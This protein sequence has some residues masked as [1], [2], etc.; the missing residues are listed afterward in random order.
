MESEL[1]QNNY[2]QI[3]RT[4]KLLKDLEQKDLFLCVKELREEIW[5]RNTCTKTAPKKNFYFVV[6]GR[7]KVFKIDEHSGRE[8]TLFLLTRDDAFDLLSLLDD[9]DHEV[10]YETL[11]KVIL[12]SAP[13]CG[14]RDW[15]S[16][17]P[18]LNKNILPYLS[19]RM[20]ILENY[21]SNIALID[22]ATRLAR[23]ILENINKESQQLELI[24]DLSNEEL[25]KLIGSTR[26]VVNRHLQDFKNEG[27]LK[28]KRHKMEIVNLQLLL[29]KAKSPS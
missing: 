17:Y 20:K 25:A 21:A 22:I 18:C 12:L 4:N 14:V 10:L 23:L 19:E 13:V 7:L 3:L 11:D 26:A 24:N 6:S 1:S 8:I 16:N 2:L 29:E 27:I 15:V 9:G 28:L 5:P